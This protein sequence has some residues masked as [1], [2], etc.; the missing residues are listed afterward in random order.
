MDV[1]KL[2]EAIIERE[3]TNDE[4]DFGIEQC[5]KKMLDVIAED[6][7]GTVAFLRNECTANEFSWLSEIFDEIVMATKSK[8]IIESLYYLHGKYPEESE[9]YNI[10]AFI[11]SAEQ[12]L[13]A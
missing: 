7:I 10:L 9:T 2:R 3:N 12:L 6:P 1:K 11:E 13:D 5:H 4:Y 8:E